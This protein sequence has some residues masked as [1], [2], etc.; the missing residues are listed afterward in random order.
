MPT[1]E[2]NPFNNLKA[3]LF[4]H[5]G[6]LVDSE[7]V[8]CQ[9]WQ[10]IL[11]QY[12]LDFHRKDYQQYYQ[13]QPSRLNAEQ[14]CEHY[15]LPVE[16]QELL[17]QKE[18]ATQRYLSQHAFPLMPGALSVLHRLHRAGIQ[19]AIVTGAD[20]QA[21]NKTLIDHKLNKLIFCVVS[22]EDVPHSKPA[23]D[24]YQHALDLLGLVPSQAVAVEDSQ[25]G[26][27]SA[28]AAKLHCIAVTTQSD[29]FS[30]ISDHQCPS[31]DVAM[32]YL[33]IE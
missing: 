13:G 16:P 17:R 25:T 28:K 32:H 23:P 10:T 8:H 22:N 2:H 11:E 14:L 7:T 4:D 1:I 3:V 26:C 9:M 18:Q 20:R 29:R 12:A 24:V 15:L 33:N 30:Q 6:T 27:Q 5:D 31:L 19:V 21:V